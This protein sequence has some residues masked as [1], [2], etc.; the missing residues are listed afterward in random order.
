MYNYRVI[1]F[2]I[3]TC[4][5]WA[6]ELVSALVAWLILSNFVARSQPTRHATIKAEGN[7]SESAVKSERGEE[8]GADLTEGL[9]D[10]ERSFPTYSRQPPLRYSSPR[11][12][13]EPAEARGPAGVPAAGGE[14]D[15]E[16]ED[17]DFIVDEPTP[18]KG[19][20][21]DSGLGTSMESSGARSD[22]VRRRRAGGGGGGNSRDG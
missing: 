18:S 10:T 5:F 13:E 17:A 8:A 3:C 20:H 7:E 9:S 19:L 16:D 1:C 4:I 14:A 11:V 2:I 21:S 22:S 15:D 6:A 12:K